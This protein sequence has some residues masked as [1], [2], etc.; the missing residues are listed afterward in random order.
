MLPNKKN[1]MSIQS[2][3]LS[4]N[5]ANQE[6]AYKLIENF[7]NASQRQI[8][9]RLK[10][11]STWTT[12]IKLLKKDKSD[13]SEKQ[14][15]E[16]IKRMERDK[17]HYQVALQ[18]SEITG[19]QAENWQKAM[20]IKMIPYFIGLLG[21]IIL[22]SLIIG[23]KPLNLENPSVIR[24]S[25]ILPVFIGLFIWG[26]LKRRTAKIEML[27]SNILLQAASAYASAK[28][29]GKSHVAAMQNLTEMKRRAKAQDAKSKEKKSK[30]KPKIKK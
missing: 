14:V 15:L 26:F 9:E 1:K 13:P 19:K 23:S 3:D 2:P 24:Y 29:Q 27:A 17:L 5:K 20:L 30:E 21:I 11:Y 4:V 12:I 28:M 10:D 16:V 22:S 18:M 6:K 8:K 7:Q 25:I